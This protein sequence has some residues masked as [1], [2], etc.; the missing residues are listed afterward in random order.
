M[1]TKK[2]QVTEKDI[3]KI[4]QNYLQKALPL[5]NK[6]FSGLK[7]SQENRWFNSFGQEQYLITNKYDLAKLPTKI[8]RRLPVHLIK[9]FV[10]QVEFDSKRYWALTHDI[11]VHAIHTTFNHWSLGPLFQALLA[12]HFANLS[13]SSVNYATYILNTVIQDVVPQPVKDLVNNR[14]VIQTYLCYPV[15]EGLTKFTMPKI[16]SSDG[17]IQKRVSD[18]RKRYEKGK[19]INSLAVLLRILETNAQTALSKP[20][21]T[22]DL[23]DFRLQTE[24]I[25]QPTYTHDDGWDSIYLLR[26]PALHGAKLAQIRSGLITNLICLIVWHLIDDKTISQALQ[27]IVHRP[28]ISTLKFGYYYPPII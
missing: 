6:S 16:V 24:S 12:S 17:V 1:A 7:G 15:L 19:K 21:F 5:F 23:R 9:Q 27:R 4:I 11:M 28:F 25:L 10:V 20:N 18:G 3:D 26:N 22:V 2:I 14:Y 8:L 13:S